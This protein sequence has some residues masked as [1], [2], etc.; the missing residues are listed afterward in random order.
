M[1]RPKSADKNGIDVYFDDWKS[2]VIA[3]SAPPAAPTR[4]AWVSRAPLTFFRSGA[5]S[6]TPIE[7][8]LRI[9]KIE[10]NCALHIEREWLSI[11]S[12]DIDR[13][14]INARSKQRPLFR[15]RFRMLAGAL[16]NA[17]R[18]FCSILSGISTRRIQ[19]II[20][21]EVEPRI[22]CLP[23]GNETEL[24]SRLRFGLRFFRVASFKNSVSLPLLLLFYAL[25]LFV[26]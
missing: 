24:T 26:Y 1:L 10:I 21:I 9:L 4:I 16:K 14:V 17:V 22:F 20:H 19:I 5:Y 15:F 8:V 7:I 13:E 6:Y 23:D 25:F 18:P 11:I 2:S 3:M 12:Q